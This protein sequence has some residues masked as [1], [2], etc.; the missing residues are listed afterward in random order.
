MQP[1]YKQVKALAP[2][3]PQCKRH[4]SGNNSSINPWPCECGVWIA[5]PKYPFTGNYQIIKA[6]KVENK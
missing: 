6:D 2:H 4:L 1:I 3:C 5:E